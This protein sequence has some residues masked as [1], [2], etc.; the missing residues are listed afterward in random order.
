M[1]IRMQ[2]SRMKWTRLNTSRQ[3]SVEISFFIYCYAALGELLKPV[4]SAPA[5]P[6]L[7]RVSGKVGSTSCGASATRRGATLRFGWAGSHLYW[8]AYAQSSLY[9]SSSSTAKEMFM[10]TY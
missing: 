6:T 2:S 3:D 10:T 5:T 9:D 7:F 8:P 4:D 1:P